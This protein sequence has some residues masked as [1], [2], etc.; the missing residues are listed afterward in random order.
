MAVSGDIS[1]MSL[2][3]R[4]RYASSAGN[5][6]PAVF[7]TPRPIVRSAKDGRRTVRHIAEKSAR[8]G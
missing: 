4:P 8:A 3:R 5:A 2:D 6:R 7:D 1:P